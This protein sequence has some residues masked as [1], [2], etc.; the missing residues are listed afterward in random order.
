MCKMVPFAGDKRVAD[1][2]LRHIENIV[3]QAAA[4]KNIKR[5]ML[6]GSATEERCTDRSD[7]DIAVFGELAKSAYLQSREFKRFQDGIFR[8]DLEQDYD[9]LY[10]SDQK[11]NRDAI[12]HDINTGTEIYRRDGI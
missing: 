3:Q 9:I 7:I 11:Q 10:F 12:L 8:F 2:K 4:A 6:F 5:I 1:I